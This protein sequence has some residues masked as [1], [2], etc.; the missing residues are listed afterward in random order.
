[1][2]RKAVPRLRQVEKNGIYQANAR[3]RNIAPPISS[4]GGDWIFLHY[5]L[6][7]LCVLRFFHQDF[8][9]IY[10]IL[11]EHFCFVASFSVARVSHDDKAKLNREHRR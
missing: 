11:L 3:K 10:F 6:R 1:M 5:L 7:L 9:F 8:F 2:V 4:P